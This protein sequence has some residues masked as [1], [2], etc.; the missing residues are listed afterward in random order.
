MN[1]GAFG[2]NFPYS[3][4]HDLNM[5]W[6]IKIAKDFL[7]QYTNIQ[8]TIETGLNDIQAK[9]DELE[10]LLDEWYNTHSEDIANELANA[11]QSI[12]DDLTASMA[13]YDEHAE[14][15]AAL[16]LA[17]I[18]DDYSL[19]SNK[20]LQEIFARNIVNDKFVDFD[21]VYEVVYPTDYIIHT[22]GPA[23]VNNRFYAN[24][25]L[26]TIEECTVTVSA[27]GYQV[28]FVNNTNSIGSWSPDSAS[29]HME[30]RNID[31]GF[32]IRKTDSSAITQADVTAILNALT[33][34]YRPDNV[35]D[36]EPFTTI[37]ESVDNTD[38]LM[39]L[40]DAFGT[41]Y[42]EVS[43]ERTVIIPTTWTSGYIDMNGI[44]HE[45]H[46]TYSYSNVIPVQEGDIFHVG[47]AE[48]TMRYVTAYDS[49]NDP[50]P[51][52]GIQQSGTYVVPNGITSIVISAMTTRVVDE[53]V[54][55]IRIRTSSELEAFVTKNP[56]DDIVY[57]ATTGS[58]LNDGKTRDTS[59]KT[60][61]HAI[62]I[63]G[64][65]ILVAQGTYTPFNITKKTN[66]LLSID[67]NYDQ[68]DRTNPKVIINGNRT[69][70]N[71]ITIS[72][73]DNIKIEN[74]EI[75]HCKKYG[76]S[77]QKSTGITFQTCVCHD[78]YYPDPSSFA[79]QGFRMIYSDVDCYDCVAY[80][81]GTTTAGT[82]GIHSDGFNIHY[83]GTVNLFNC[84]AYNCMDD[85]VSHH[86]GSQGQIVGGEWYNCGKGGI[87]SP[88]HG[89]RVNV[90]GVYSH[91]NR[92]GFFAESETA[93]TN[94]VTVLLNS[95]AFK[96]NTTKDIYSDNN[97]NV[98][99]INCKYDQSSSSHLTII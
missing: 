54:P 33:I 68:N 8:N 97:Y 51:N 87:A 46:A 48:Y 69:Y 24:H 39:L 74:F 73:S 37:F 36:S 9:A 34:S 85:G 38:H 47:E 63:G 43:R 19:L 20:M 52:A 81:I 13:E 80:N 92:Y 65:V 56:F 66:V 26:P 44:V 98:I 71:G 84:S 25:S 79:S 41:R 17:S 16:T 28:V 49:N 30:N 5:D 50:V 60:I 89:A 78:I 2:E 22:L 11:L 99:A 45:P 91:D 64:R 6:I 93:L 40:A 75:Q 62:D 82:G 90:Y 67:H 21:D 70:E 86:E 4:F 95:C 83:T 35:Y 15:K 53:G 1:N 32:W 29:M 14:E 61:Q 3:N 72:G 77:V 55:V 59:V 7:D 94:R 10:G 76:I 27:P 18:P 42:E 31:L 12:A 88:T 58:D 23:N 96:N 57:V